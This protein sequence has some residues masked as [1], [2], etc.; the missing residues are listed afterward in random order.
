MLVGV[1][2]DMAGFDESVSVSDLKRMGAVREIQ[3]PTAS[4]LQE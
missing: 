2:I 4:H 3:P 1:A